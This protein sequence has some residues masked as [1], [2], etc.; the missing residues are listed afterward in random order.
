MIRRLVVSSDE[1][2]YTNTTLDGLIDSTAP[3]IKID[4][5]QNTMG[6]IA[7]IEYF[8]VPPRWLFVKITDEDSNFGWGEASLE[9]HT[10]A[11]EGC[12]DA[13]GE[14]YTGFEAE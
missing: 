2:T 4:S 1:K 13:W 5:I 10:Q 3:S 8:R 11:V 7:K 12:L 6:K 14:R 9:G